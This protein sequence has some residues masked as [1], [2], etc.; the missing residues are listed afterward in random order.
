VTLS[1]QGA[2]IIFC[3]LVTVCVYYTQRFQKMDRRLFSGGREK[4]EVTL[5]KR[6]IRSLTFTVQEANTKPIQSNITCLIKIILFFSVAI[7]FG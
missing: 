4:R 5:F 2:F 1:R 3:A 6:D 7:S